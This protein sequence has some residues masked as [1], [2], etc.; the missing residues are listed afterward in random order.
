LR[1]LVSPVGPNGRPDPTATT[2]VRPGGSIIA[3][4][5]G[6]RF[7][8]VKF[9]VQKRDLASTVE[10]VREKIQNLYETP[11]WFQMGG[12]FEQM[13]DAEQRLLYIIP[14]SLIGIFLLLYLAFRSLLDAV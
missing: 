7:I 9:S 4:E 11:Y 1:N 10:E 14:A 3:R 5:N 8:A 2:F 13:G 6:K 12:E